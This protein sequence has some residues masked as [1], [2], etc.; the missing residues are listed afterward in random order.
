MKKKIT[1]IIGLVLCVVMLA[2]IAPIAQFAQAQAVTLTV[3]NP[4][5]E[6][7]KIPITPL[8]ER[9]DTLEGKKIAFFPISLSDYLQTSMVTLFTERF[10]PS[11]DNEFGI[12]FGALNA[13]SG[14]AHTDTYTS[15]ETGARVADAVIVGTA[16]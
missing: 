9:L 13:K 7:E 5:A 8:A 15:Y 10:G 12:T 16:F 14:V 2:S 1:K 4:K 6:V 3:L 11:G